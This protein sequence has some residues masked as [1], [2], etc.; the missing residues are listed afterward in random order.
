[1]VNPNVNYQIKRKVACR[2]EL[3][4]L[5]EAQGSSPMY[6]PNELNKTANSNPNRNYTITWMS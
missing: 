2:Q 3:R 5:P 6:I 1:M 4:N